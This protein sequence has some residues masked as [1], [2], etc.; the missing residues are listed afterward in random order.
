MLGCQHLATSQF[1]LN[2]IAPVPT[3]RAEH[4]SMSSAFTDYHRIL[5]PFFNLWNNACAALG[6][7]FCLLIQQITT[8]GANSCKLARIKV[9][10][11]RYIYCTVQW[12]NMILM[13]GCYMNH[14]ANRFSDSRRICSPGHLWPQKQKRTCG[15]VVQTAQRGTCI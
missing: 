10:V 12:E 14:C 9:D 6:V 11:S 2:A 1:T 7:A 8:R 13:T 5:C 3:A 4:R 15:K